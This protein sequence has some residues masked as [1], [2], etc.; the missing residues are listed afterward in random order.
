VGC[1]APS[2]AVHAARSGICEIVA[3]M[4]P[5]WTSLAARRGAFWLCVLVVLAL[6]LLPPAPYL[7]ATPWD[8]ANHVL[9]FAVLM[10][11]GCGSYRDRT[12]AVLLGLLAYGGAIELL[13][14][15]T[16]YRTG[17]VTDLLADATGL[18]LGWP[19]ARFFAQR[20]PSGG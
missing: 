3:R 16:P 15:L 7:P 13:Q 14:A 6:A 18:L 4:I 9:A 2:A 5:H 1:R 17:D 12:T 10:L 8:K 20:R 19:L 11:L